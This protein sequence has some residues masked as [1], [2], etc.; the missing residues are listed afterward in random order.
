M[1]G[2]CPYCKQESDGS[3]NPIC[4]RAVNDERRL[5]PN[6]EIEYLQSELTRLRAQLSAK[7]ALIEEARETLKGIADAPRKNF[8]DIGDDNAEE[9]RR[10]AKSRARY[11]LAKLAAELEEGKGEG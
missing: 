9:F 8:D 2:K 4:P 6:N 7:N 10:W 3:H 5:F 1:N 11:I